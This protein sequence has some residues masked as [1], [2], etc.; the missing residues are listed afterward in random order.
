MHVLRIFPPGMV[1]AEAEAG[2]GKSRC[3]DKGRRE[4]EGERE[5]ADS[6]GR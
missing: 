2:R 5:E 1:K 4:D 6:A 3:E